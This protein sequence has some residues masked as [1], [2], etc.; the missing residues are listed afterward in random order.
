MKYL[1][2]LLFFG[3]QVCYAFQISTGAKSI[4]LQSQT[5]LIPDGA[6]TVFTNPSL[7][8][9]ISHRSIWFSVFNPY[10]LREVQCISSAFSFHFRHLSYGVGFEQLGYKSFKEQLFNF[11]IARNFSDMASLGV[12]LK[13]RQIE[14]DRYGSAGQFIL[15]FGFYI[16]LT[17]LI[18]FGTRMKNV[19]HTK[20]SNTDEIIERELISG[21]RF[22]P[23]SEIAFYVETMHIEHN[24]PDLRIA[25]TYSPIRY[26]QLHV[27][28]GFNSISNFST[29][30][31][32]NWYKL[33]FAYALQNHPF[34]SQTH[35]FT[36]SLEVE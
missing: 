4:A 26:L 6:G 23:L 3:T 7:L 1:Y 32:L 27:G 30:F 16:P 9:Q 36:I 33:N 34:L 11:S 19:Y 22:M 13:Y 35:Y 10:Q 25:T 2:F 21:I 8:P 31:C 20:L 24:S 15:D 28:T 14:I 29:G 17:S 18:D 5:A 12:S